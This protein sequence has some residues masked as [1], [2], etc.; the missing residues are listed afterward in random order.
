MEST[1][2]KTTIPLYGGGGG[3][4]GAVPSPP[5]EAPPYSKFGEVD[6]V[7]AEG[8]EYRWAMRGSP[9]A[10]IEDQS[11]IFFARI[12]IQQKTRKEKNLGTPLGGTTRNVPGVRGSLWTDRWPEKDLRIQLL[13]VGTRHVYEG[14][15]RAIYAKRRRSTAVVHLYFPGLR[16]VDDV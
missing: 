9:Q 13:R 2:Q 10:R 12:P 3:G 1:M 16:Q 14:R 8:R 7:D 4:G 5:L 15:I 6:F 11:T